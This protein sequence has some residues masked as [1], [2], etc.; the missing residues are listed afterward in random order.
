MV[1]LNLQAGPPFGIL[2]L[3]NRCL[4]E[5]LRLFSFTLARMGRNRWRGIGCHLIQLDKLSDEG[6]S[7]ELE[8]VI[9]G[10]SEE[11]GESF[12]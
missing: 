1:I 8:G 5:V 11:R 6:F 4:T 7:D 12:G 2:V 10:I 3:S 9:G